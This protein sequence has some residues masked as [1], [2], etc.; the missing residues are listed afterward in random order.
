MSARPETDCPRCAEALKRFRA[1]FP[2]L[3]PVSWRDHDPIGT[4]GSYCAMQSV[5][6]CGPATY[7]AARG[8]VQ[9]RRMFDT[10]SASDPWSPDYA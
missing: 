5:E 1:A 9:V 7:N 4:P 3:T 6:C 10:S 8:Y 2:S